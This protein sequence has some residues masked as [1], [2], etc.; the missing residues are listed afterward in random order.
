MVYE[1][2]EGDIEPFLRLYRL[3]KAK[4]MDVKQVVDVLAIANDDLPTLE[5]RFKRLRN[6]ISMLQFRRHTC[7]R[8]L[9][10][11]NNQIAST[12]KRLISYRVSCIRERREIEN[13]YNEKAKLEA[14]VALRSNPELG[15]FMFYNISNNTYSSNYLSLM[16][17]GG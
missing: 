11:L 16:S 3:S 12:T 17:S 13:L 6:D 9:Y 5:K 15:N 8:S 1:E 2:L 4:G 10:Q 14:I 7:E